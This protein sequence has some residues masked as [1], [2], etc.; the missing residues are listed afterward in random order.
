MSAWGRAR[1]RM[2]RADATELA[3]KK[4]AHYNPPALFIG[5]REGCSFRASF[6]PAHQDRLL[7]TNTLHFFGEASERR[8]WASKREDRPAVFAAAPNCFPEPRDTGSC[9]HRRVSYPAL[10][11]HSTL[12]A[13]KNGRK[14]SEK[15]A[16]KEHENFGGK[17]CGSLQIGPA[18]P[19]AGLWTFQSQNVLDNWAESMFHY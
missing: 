5:R 13:E 4:S 3:P 10:T 6:N 15:S 1:A 17:D 16:G 12:W 8:P 14:E 18:L 2:P 11:T 9:L 7:S 19:A